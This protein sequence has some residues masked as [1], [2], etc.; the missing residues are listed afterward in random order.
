M[1]TLRETRNWVSGQSFAVPSGWRLKNR[2]SLFLNRYEGNDIELLRKWFKPVDVIVE[3]GANIGV[4]ARYAFLN[5]LNDGGNY[6]CIEP[7]PRSFDALNANMLE[8]QRAAPN[9]NYTIIQAAV[10]PPPQEG[11]E[12]DFLVRPNLRSGLKSHIKDSGNEVT[13]KVATISL[14]SIMRKYAPRG[15]SLICDAEGGEIPVIQQDPEAFA[16][17]RQI[18]IELH[19]PSLTGQQETQETMLKALKGLGFRLEEQIRDS[20]CLTHDCN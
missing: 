14:S 18:E 8:A 4:V 16:N 9:R 3:I 2:L 1:A 19:D 10:C 6:I 15:A 12:L 7:N 17:I 11:Q 13:A 20:Y 5:K